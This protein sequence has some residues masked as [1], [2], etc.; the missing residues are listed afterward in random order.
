[1]NPTPINHGPMGAPSDKKLCACGAV[2]M[3]NISIAEG[4]CQACRNLDGA[5]RGR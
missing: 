1:M 2:L 4:R 5:G 3:R